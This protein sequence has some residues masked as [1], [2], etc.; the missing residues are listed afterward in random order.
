MTA[1]PQVCISHHFFDRFFDWSK[2]SHWQ[3][4][5]AH[6]SVSDEYAHMCRYGRRSVGGLDVSGSPRLVVERFQGSV[7]PEVGG[8][9]AWRCRASIG[10]ALNAVLETPPWR[11]ATLQ[12][13]A[14]AS[15]R[16]NA[17]RGIVN[18]CGHLK[19][20]LCGHQTLND[21][22]HDPIEPCR[23]FGLRV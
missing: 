18:L 2:K 15:K 19:M 1:L 13:R 9:P 6:P 8:V 16:T 10:I 7:E 3:V 20:G 22:I 12:A 5:L 21:A 4:S 23:P 14:N 11:H 17:R